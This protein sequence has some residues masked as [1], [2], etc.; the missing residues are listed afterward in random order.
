[1]KKLNFNILPSSK[2]R[3]WAMLFIIIL[4]VCTKEED[5]DSP[6]IPP[7]FSFVMDFSD[8]S[9]NKKSMPGD[10]II[11]NYTKLNWAFAATNVVVWNV[12]LTINLAI[13]VAAF[14]ESFNHTPEYQSNG[15]WIWSYSYSILGAIY[16][17]KLQG[18]LTSTSVEWEMYI[19]KEGDYTDFLWFT[20]ESNLTATEGSW[21]LYYLSTIPTPYIQI[22][23]HRSADQTGISDIK[24]TNITPGGSEYGSYILYG[25]DYGALLDAFYDIYLASKT[26]LTE[27]EWNRTD[28]DGRVR[29]SIHFGD[30][31]WHCWNSTLD[32]ID[33]E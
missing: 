9:N 16:T 13:P 10:D 15:L 27:I 7:V 20:G 1:M 30:T 31:L 32:D 5:E 8:F 33:C 18:T 2:Y 11:A 21:T 23:W 3:I 25:L 22:D 19:S 24:Y 6:E 17:A 26:N 14:V 4:V 12:V 28:K 29:D